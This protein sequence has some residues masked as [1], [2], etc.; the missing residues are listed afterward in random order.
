MSSALIIFIK[1]PELGKAKTR[2]AKTTGPERALEIYHQLLDHTR[3]VC[4]PVKA[5]KY[6]FYS[7]FID[8]DDAWSSEHFHKRLQSAGNLGSKISHAFQSLKSDYDNILIIG[9]DCLD[10]EPNI[11]ESALDSLKNNQVVIG[12]TYDGGYYLIGS[13][14]YY[15]ELFADIAWSTETVYDQTLEAAIN[16]DLSVHALPKLNDVDYESDWIE[17]L[18]RRKARTIGM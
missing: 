6:L 1:N 13:Q 15:P 16:S 18:E 17:A 8:N 12:P 10:L 14:G 7:E 11:I 2:I 3:T 4:E 9:S 5:D